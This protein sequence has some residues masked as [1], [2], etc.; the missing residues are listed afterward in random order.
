LLL[1]AAAAQPGA[2]RNLP[3]FAATAYGPN[4]DGTYPCTG[5]GDGVPPNCAPLPVPIGFSINFYGAGFSSLYV[6][7]N[8]N[9]TFD[10]PLGGYTPF[11]LAHTGRE[12]IAPFFADVDTRTGNTLTFGNDTVDGHQAFG[13]NWLD[14][15]YYLTNTDKLNSFQLVLVDRSDRDPGDFDIEF[16]YNQIQWETGD[17]RG[18]VDGLGGSSA[19]AGFSDGSGL[20][21]TYFQL[22]GSAIPGEF[23]DNNPGG[24]IHGGLNTNV[25]GRYLIPIVNLTNR[26]LNVPLFSQGDPRWAAGTYADSGFT[27]QQKGCALSSLAMALDYA[28]VATD[29]GALDSLLDADGDFVGT[30]VDW[31]GA[32]RDAS[33]NTLHFHAYRTADTQYLSQT[34]AEGY[35]V[36]VGVNLNTSGCPSH[37]VL[38]IGELNGGFIIND[39]G[40]ADAP[41]LDYYDNTFETRG[42]VGD[43]PGD[44]S[45]FDI[46]VDGAPDL[47]VVDPLGRR[48][49]YDPAS[50]N[51]LAEIP[52]AVHFSE[53]I[54]DS[55]LTGAPGT[56]TA[57]TVEIDQPVQGHYQILLVGTN[58]GGYQLTLRAFSRNGKP[59][60]PLALQGTKAS[61]AIAQAQ[62]NLASTGA[63]TSE[64][65]TNEYPWS[66]SPTNGPLPLA[67]QFT[68]PDVDSRGNAV[69]TWNWHFGDGLTGTQQNPSHTYTVGGTFLP[70]LT[71][72]DHAGIT[73][74]GFGPAILLPTVAYAANPTSGRVPLAVQ[75]TSPTR[76]SGDNHIVSWNWDFGDGSASTLPDPSHSY[77]T[78]GSFVPSLTATN[79]NGL[80][81]SGLGPSVTVSFPTVAYAANPTNGRVPLTVQFTAAGLD[82]ASNAIVSWNWDFGDHYAATG[83]NPSHTYTANGVFSPALVAANSAGIE[84]LG[85]GPAI[86]ATIAPVDLGLVV[87]GGF[88]TGDFSGWTSN[89]NFT[90]TSVTN[91]SASVHSGAFGAAFGASGSLGYLAQ[92][93]PTVAG[94]RYALSFWL[95]NPDGQTPNEFLVSWDGNT[96]LGETNLP[97]IGWT[98][99]QL[100]VTATGTTT[101][102]QFG[103]QDDPSFLALDD[104]SVFPQPAI[105]GIRLSGT[106]LVVDGSN[107]LVGAPCYV[108]MSTNLAQPLSQ[109]MPVATNNLPATGPFSITASNAV[110]PNAPQRFYTLRLQ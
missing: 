74:A 58:G 10:Q 62:V 45:G 25:P 52:Q 80:T 70:T 39:P 48:T 98:N 95:N 97:A 50:G 21:G 107:G 64:P 18:A 59:E 33:G 7:N 66:V 13:V 61:D 16:N 38:V 44:V 20:P 8:G 4:D 99:V 88:E 40:H 73:V 47:L 94:A 53:C 82:S 54:E 84:V 108:L 9:V 24:L 102:L 92:T 41:T 56:D 65:F 78:A 71:A 31:D 43:A 67:V 49:G 37:F 2:I 68:S 1:Q 17:G 86:D 75:F 26:F 104:I 6:N 89:G 77:I 60:P 93:L 12:I 85:S 35:P 42:Y 76:D 105:T 63:I 30:S 90:S 5:P 110:S 87:N 55:D 100:V 103:F 83:Q 91:D 3:G 36:I 72:I 23:P 34:L 51:I 29:P 32:T 101:I 79:N 106:N 46:S 69:T 81:V 14:V 96:L 15:G 19:V 57:H 22:N 11:G 27:I 109:W 28:G